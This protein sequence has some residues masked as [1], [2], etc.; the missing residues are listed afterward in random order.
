[1]AENNNYDPIEIF[2]ERIKDAN[3]NMEQLVGEMN[4]LNESLNTNITET[5][6]H[7]KTINTIFR[8]IPDIIDDIE[9]KA[10]LIKKN[11]DELENNIKKTIKGL[12]KENIIVSISEAILSKAN[13]KKV[14]IVLIMS[15]AISIILSYFALKSYLNKPTPVIAKVLKKIQYK[16]LTSKKHTYIIFQ[17]TNIQ[18]K[19]TKLGNPVIIINK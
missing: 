7:L 10:S 1:M 8:N 2:E 16:V 11:N 6:K 14:L 15:S 13:F 5:K 12:K 3:Q 18:I 9:K 4:L 17:N 19:Y